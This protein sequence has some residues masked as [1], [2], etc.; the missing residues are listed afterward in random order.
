MSLLSEL[1]AAYIPMDRRQVMVQGKDLPN[2]TRGAALFADVSGF[3]PLTEALV[4]QLGPRRGADELTKQL[5]LVYDALIAEVHR[6]RGSVITFSGD[7][8][9]CWFDADEGLSA[10]TCALAM[11]AAMAQFAEVLTPSGS[12]I[13]LAMKV[14][15][16]TG[17]VRRFLVGDPAIQIM[18][19]LA[20]ATLDRMAAGEHHAQRGEIILDE[21]TAQ[22]LR[23]RVRITEWR[24]DDATGMRFGVVGDLARPIADHPWP[25]LAPGVF[26]ETQLQPWLLPPVYEKLSTGQAQFLAELRPGVALFLSFGGLDYDHDEA[27]GETLDRY[28]RWVQGV[29]ARYE[30][31]MF[32]LTLGDKGCYLY[33]AFGAPLAHDDDPARAVAAALELRSP[34]PEMAVISTVRIGV[35]QGRMRAGA[36]GASTRRTYGVI[37]DEVNIAARLMGKAQ[38][39]QIIASQRIVEAVASS[40][41]LEYLG[42]V[43]VKGKQE[44]LPVSLVL[45]R[46]APSAKGVLALYATPLVGRDRELAR[47]A[48]ILAQVRSGQGQILRLQ[49]V[50]G[51]G[52]SH[53]AATIARQLE[54]QGLRVLLGACQSINQGIAYYLWQQIA[55]AL[56]ELGTEST[57]ER[58]STEGVAR[59]IARVEARINEMRSEWFLRL[60]LLGDLLGLPIPDNETTAAFDPKMRQEA[61]VALVVE[62]VRTWAELR[63][64]VLLLEDVHWIDEA[65][66]AMT[67][68]VARAIADVP[69]LLV[70]VQRPPLDVDQP[71]L[72]DLD[73]LAHHT[74]LDLNELSPE[75]VAALVTYRLRGPISELALDL[76]QAQAQGNPFFTEELVDTLRES[77]DLHRRDDVWH[78]SDAMIEAL[79]HANCLTRA[80]SGEGW[81]LTADAHLSAADL[82]IPDTIHGIVLSRLDRLPES[83]KLTLKVA[84]VIGR[85]FEFNVLTQSYPVHVAKE[86]L[87]AQMQML[88]SRDFSRLE[89]PPPHLAYM[90]K[91]AITQEVTYDTLL[92][93]QRRDLH[94]AVGEALEAL[95]PEAVECL[96][97]HYS[98]SGARDKALIYLDKAAARAQQD[99]ANETALNYYAQALDLEPR[100]EWRKG[101]VEVLHILGRR[102]EEADALRALEAL[103]DAPA[104]EVAYLWG[105]YYEAISDYPQARDKVEQALLL[106]QTLQDQV[107]EINCLDRLGFIAWRQGQYDDAKT[108][109]Q[110]AL[111]LLEGKGAYLDEEARAFAQVLNGLGTVH[112]QQGQFDEAKAC[113]ERALGLNRRVGDSVGEAR[114]LS[115]LGAAT[116]Y[117]RQLTDA[118]TY[119]Q[120]ALEI[121]KAIGDRAGEGSSLANMGMTVSE[122]GDYI[123]ANEYL[124]ASLSIQ[125]TV[126]NRWEEINLCNS[127]GILHQELGVLAGAKRHLETGLALSQ[128][129]GDMAGQT[130]LL[131]NLGLVMRDQGELETAKRVLSNGL[132]LSEKENNAYA[133]SYFLSYLGTVSLQMENVDE[134]VVQASKALQLRQELDMKLNMADDLATLAVA[135]LVSGAA[136]KALNYVEQ[137]WFILDECGGEGPEFPQRDYFVCYQVFAAAEQQ[138]LAQ[139]AL[140]SAYALVITKANKIIDN[141]LRQSFL[142]RVLINRV[143]VKEYEKHQT[144]VS[145]RA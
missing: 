125:R 46:R 2:R 76:I 69:V 16:A 87:A 14:A 107:R 124:L 33:G 62:M 130:Y 89:I 106:S 128:E 50:A 17:P 117:Q 3:T 95:Q 79:R 103:P 15:V 36:Y 90:F 85:T 88:E 43:Q 132:A 4:A 70:L 116:L 30:G 119:H 105:Q 56:F 98:R 122:M 44:P 58:E 102:E 92:E 34:P 94:K 73:H 78:L 137:A 100:W 138:A 10:M 21:D 61:L 13:S 131:A 24:E 32:Q 84:G 9:T 12:T 123:R 7:A 20:G 54:D 60:P 121:R 35:S 55:C 144:N 74:L 81:R 27:A 136:E 6:F 93:E 26:S 23:A 71:L 67:L 8:I 126:G 140:Q 59:Q 64:L 111:E 38:P 51:V 42:P 139:I 77:G 135:Y 31:Y 118:L 18:D 101:Q 86:M 72:P 129:I 133:A 37:G 113:Y 25:P 5:N 40:Y 109:Y 127:L 97:Y 47:S 48:D 99:Y 65:S 39:G 91:H 53:L 110:Q 75:G 108:W 114:T 112:R 83:H 143:I 134:A 63:P 104:F 145:G 45:S 19:V 96:A 49:G 82:G 120:Q 57:E 80:S 29:L 28:L 115:N 41:D 52:K 22:R 142:E 1:L 66:Q 141:D 11:Q 68:A